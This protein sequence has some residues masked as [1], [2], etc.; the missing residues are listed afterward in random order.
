ME[1]KK[2]FVQ[3]K[4]IKENFKMIFRVIF[5]IIF[6]GLSA[7]LIATQGLYLVFFIF[8]KIDLIRSIKIYSCFKSASM[9]KSD[10]YRGNANGTS[11]ARMGGL[12]RRDA[13]HMAQANDKC[14]TR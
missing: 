2:S 3:I 7:D 5:A 9:R 4:K 13:Q 14:L 6:I 11:C 1:T 10:R 12:W 8:V